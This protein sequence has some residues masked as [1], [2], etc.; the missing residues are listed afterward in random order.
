MEEIG[1]LQESQAGF[2][3]GRRTL[4]NIFILNHIIQRD[5]M[6]KEG[7]KIYALFVDLKA[8][9][10]NVDRGKL[11]DILKKD[12]I[13]RQLI[14]RIEGMYEET[15]TTV[16]TTEGLTSMF[17]TLKGVRQG[18]VLSP[19][20]FNLYVAELDKRLRNRKIGGVK[21][22]IERIWTLSY[23]DDMVLVAKNKEA[24]EDMMGTLRKFLKNR[25][26][27]LNVEKTKIVVFNRGRNEKKEKWKKWKWED[28]ELE[29][30]CFKYLGFVF[31]RNEDYKEHLKDLSRKGKVAAN[32]VWGL[33]E[34]IYRND[35]RRR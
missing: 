21:L 9:F 24:L 22:G 19:Q 26:L 15:Y 8:A 18:C 32:K 31:N 14:G 35:F 4:D 23:A 3:R 29:V 25:N 6:A 27:E 20:L 12:G 30:R 1:I 17:R 10:D 7:K 34:R 16:K 13:N 5:R 2:R 28:K 11:C 33:G